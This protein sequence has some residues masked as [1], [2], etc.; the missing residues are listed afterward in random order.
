MIES[1]LVET[2]AEHLNSKFLMSQEGGEPMEVEL[3]T[4]LDLGS[5]ARQIQFSLI[6]LAPGRPQPIQGMYQMKHDKLG[7]FDLFLVPVNADERGLQFEAI[8]NRLIKQEK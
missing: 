1:A 2:F 8:F 6:F 4:A 3:I 7:E 5:N